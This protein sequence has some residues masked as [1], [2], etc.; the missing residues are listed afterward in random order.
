MGWCA[1][2]RIRAV[3]RGDTRQ[4]DVKGW[5]RATL[6]PGTWH[7]M[8][9]QRLQKGCFRGFPPK[10][11]HYVSQTCKKPCTGLLSEGNSQGGAEAWGVPG[12]PGWWH[13]GGA[14]P[15]PSPPSYSELPTGWRRAGRRQPFSALSFW[16]SS[17]QA[18]AEI[19]QAFGELL[20]QTGARYPTAGF[21]RTWGVTGAKASCGQRGREDVRGHGRDFT[22]AMKNAC[23]LLGKRKNRVRESC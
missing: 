12:E 1:G 2:D 18:F 10:V 23:L 11:V 7:P 17:K 19:A 3:F 4:I 22:T 15:S 5:R 20:I 16:F 14:S 13:G 9:A 8:D 6:L 21:P